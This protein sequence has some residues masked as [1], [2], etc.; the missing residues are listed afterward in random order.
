MQSTQ[1]LTCKH[2]IGLLRCDAFPDG[3]PTAIITGEYDHTQPY[4]GDKGIRWE[5]LDE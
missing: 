3:I 2:S 5:K 4:K 1:C